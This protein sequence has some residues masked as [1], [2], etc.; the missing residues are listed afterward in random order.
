MTVLYDDQT[1]ELVRWLSRVDLGI[2]V[3]TQR[4][5]LT[6]KLEIKHD[7]IG[8]PNLQKVPETLLLGARLRGFSKLFSDLASFF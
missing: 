3:G 4:I 1:C 5:I 7:K 2:L 6:R 8:R